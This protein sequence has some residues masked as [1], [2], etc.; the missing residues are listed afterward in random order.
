MVTTHNGRHTKEYYKYVYE[1]I[2]DAKTQA[3]VLF[4]IQE[5]RKLLLKGDLILGKVK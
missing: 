1:K 4:E 5:I 2:K 3:D